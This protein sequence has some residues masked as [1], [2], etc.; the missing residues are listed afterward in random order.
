MVIVMRV[1]ALAVPLLVL[2]AACGDEPDHSVATYCAQVQTD[3]TSL[4]TPA[5]STAADID[6]TL[7]MYRT[8]GDV[9]PAA[10]APE[11]QTMIDSLETAATLVPDDPEGLA[12]VN[13]AALSSQSAATRIAQYTQQQ[14][15]VDI[16]TPPAP[17]NPVTATTVSPPATT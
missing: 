2:G 8:I 6:T 10:V 9:A 1:A 17:T 3:L 11:W 15:K 7:A 4:N 16:G 12:A 14:C 13:E 5:I